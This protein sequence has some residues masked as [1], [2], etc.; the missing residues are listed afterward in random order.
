M[1]P[2]ASHSR[3]KQ[4]KS[5][6][7][8]MIV[9]FF[10][11]KTDPTPLSFVSEFP[12]YSLLRGDWSVLLPILSGEGKESYEGSFLLDDVNI[13]E[14]EYCFA[15]VAI[16][17]M[18]TVSSLPLKKGLESSPLNQP[19]TKYR[20]EHNLSDELFAALT[21]AITEL[22]NALLSRPLYTILDLSKAEPGFAKAVN[23][24]SHIIFASYRILVYQ[25][26]EEGEARLTAFGA[27]PSLP[28]FPV[29]FADFDYGEK[30]EQAGFRFFV[31]D[32]T[33]SEALNP[34][35]MFARRAEKI[36][37]KKQKALEA[38]KGG[39]QNPF[40]QSFTLNVP[41]AVLFL[42]F[43][44]LSGI[45]FFYLAKGDYNGTVASI[46]SILSPIFA[47]MTLMPVAFFYLDSP[48]LNLL[49]NKPLLGGLALIGGV[50]LILGLAEF[51]FFR[52]TDFPLSN[53]LPFILP[54]LGFP[55][56]EAAFLLVLYFIRKK[57]SE[58]EE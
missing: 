54:L 48:E 30:G 33:D 27:E 55:L 41:F 28:S 47:L 26:N 21:Q 50:A 20:E 34:G 37:K 24:L 1:A 13:L 39:Q 46:F 22:Y 57:R 2:L 19:L 16:N 45:A 9:A 49:R 56:M 58:L 23:D 38:K 51:L 17:G 32:I 25:G 3:G 18:E 14:D 36:K 8:N 35:H 31:A 4:V 15:S 5:C 42:L 52:T 6:L 10:H 44:C 11:L 53:Q 29:T 40:K 43:C 7:S 12:G